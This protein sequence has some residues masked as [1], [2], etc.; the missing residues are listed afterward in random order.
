M[1]KVDWNAPGLYYILNYRSLPNG[2]VVT[3]RINDS[4]V[5]VFRVPN[6]GYYKQ[7]GFQ[8]QAG[9]D[10]GVG[11]MSPLVTLYSVPDP[12][13][14]RPEDVKVGAVGAH[15]VEL[16]WRPVD[17]IRGRVDGYR[18]SLKSIYT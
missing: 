16:L 18:V 15:T 1:P 6:P 12:P 4:S 13:S 10:Q 7:W 5:S 17:L 14:K 8:M 3:H 9:N 11:P 2:T